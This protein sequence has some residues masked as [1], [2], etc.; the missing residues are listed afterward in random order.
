MVDMKLDCFI[1][2]LE[3]SVICQISFHHKEQ[4]S[5]SANVEGLQLIG[6]VLVVSASYS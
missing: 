3:Q 6:M 1:E 5:I 2:V 4:E